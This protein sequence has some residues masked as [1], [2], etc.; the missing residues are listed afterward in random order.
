M[1]VRGPVI[2]MFLMC[3]IFGHLI[4]SHKN[5]L[6][7]AKSFSKSEDLE[8]EKRLQTINKPAVKNIK[9]SFYLHNLSVVLYIL[10]IQ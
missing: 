5:D 1:E 2:W 8:I 7:E 10:I 6:V 3:C 4:V 9:V